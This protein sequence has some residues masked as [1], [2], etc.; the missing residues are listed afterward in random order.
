MVEE[1]KKQRIG[2]YDTCEEVRQDS[3]GKMGERG[4]NFP[5]EGSTLVHHERKKE[6]DA[7]VAR[8]HDEIDR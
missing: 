1:I 3:F 5:G 7:F 2:V 4:G 6:N 8:D